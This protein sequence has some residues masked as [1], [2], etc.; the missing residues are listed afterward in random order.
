MFDFAHASLS[1]KLTIITMLATG[2]AL[3]IVFCALSFSEI[4][5]RKSEQ[6]RQLSSFA[7]VIAANSRA[8]ITFGDQKAAIETL[9]ALSVKPEVVVA[10]TYGADGKLFARYSAP[11]RGADAN[12]LSS[13]PDTI[14]TT[15]VRDEGLSFWATKVRVS[16]PVVQKGE[17]LGMVLIQA[18]LSGM[19]V[20]I[21]SKLGVLGG[22]TVLAFWIAISLA[23]GFRK[24]ISDPLMRLVDAAQKVSLRKDYT[25]RVEKTSDDELGILVDGFNEMLAQIELRDAEVERSRSHL[26]EQVQSRTAELEKA[27]ES[28]EAASRAKSEFLATMSHEIRTPMNGVLGMTELLLATAADER[29]RRLSEGIKTSGEHLLSL[30]NSILDFSKIEAGRLELESITFDVRALVEVAASMFAQQAQAKGLELLVDIA[31]GLDLTASGDPGRLRQVL[32]NLIGN[33]LKFTDSGQ[34]IVRLLIVEEKDDFRMLRFQVEDTGIGIPQAA[35][36]RIFESFTQADGSTTRKYGGTGLGLA[37]CKRLVGM[38]GGTIGLVSTSGQGSTFWFS[39]RLRKIAAAA[40]ASAIPDVLR[41]M[42]VLIADENANSCMLIKR[43]VEYW[44]MRAESV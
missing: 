30:I 21:A 6:W 43:Q 2:A 27:K 32:A 24:S 29:Q 3:S 22:A 42:R 11:S 17:Q 13:I 35:Q 41:G 14:S 5:S 33:A 28:A 25:L 39:A 26:E 40:T 20:D 16:R 12:G 23:G 19:W 18:D 8:A 4:I 34:V 31:P 9:S 36:A 37:I 7:D 44:Q 38:M 1:R 15:G 10:A